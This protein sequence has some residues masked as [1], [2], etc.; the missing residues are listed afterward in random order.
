M[1]GGNAQARSVENARLRALVEV[2]GLE[3]QKDAL[4]RYDAEMVASKVRR[5]NTV[6]HNTKPRP[7]EEET[8]LGT[9]GLL[10]A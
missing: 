5:S 1:V 8:L 2:A 6:L 3:L 7:D 10:N 4:R 9:R